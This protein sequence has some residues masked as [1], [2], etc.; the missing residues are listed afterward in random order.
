MIICRIPN[1][2]ADPSSCLWPRNLRLLGSLRKA[3][4]WVHFA[5]RPEWDGGYGCGQG[6]GRSAD[7]LVHGV[8]I[9]QHQGE[10]SREAYYFDNPGQSYLDGTDQPHISVY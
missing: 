9:V 6:T 8:E 10:N 5:R 3:P 4:L 1:W 7:D 2:P